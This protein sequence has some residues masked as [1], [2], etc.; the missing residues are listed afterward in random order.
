[1]S[2][3]LQPMF[4][5]ALRPFLTDFDLVSPPKHFGN[6]F[7]LLILAL[8]FQSGEFGNLVR[9][10][11]IDAYLQVSVFVQLGQLYHLSLR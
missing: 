6:S 9:N 10:S 3:F 1:M 5:I 2:I 11:M 4:A 7:G 8:A